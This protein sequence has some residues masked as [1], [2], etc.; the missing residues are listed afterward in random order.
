M[1]PQA[2]GR[3]RAGILLALAADLA[4]RM[5]VSAIAQYVVDVGLDVI[6]ASAGTLCLLETAVDEFVVVAQRGYPE[7]VIEAWRRFPRNSPAPAA[8]AVARREPVY[9]R[10]SAAVKERYPVF[11]KLEHEEGATAILPVIARGRA[12]GAVAFTFDGEREFDDE[13]RTFLE[14]M[15]RHCA[16]ALDRA[17]IHEA[18]LRRETHLALIADASSVLAAQGDDLTEA[19]RSVARLIVPVLSD[20]C[21][22]FLVEGRAHGRLVA[23]AA[24]VPDARTT[25][26]GLGDEYRLDIAKAQR[27]TP[28]IQTSTVV[29]WEEGQSF[30]DHIGAPDSLRR[31]MSELSIGPGALVPLVARGRAV[32]MLALANR[33]GRQPGAD[34][35]ALA[36]TLGQRMAVLIDNARLLAQTTEISRSLQ[37]SLLPPMLPEIEGFEIAAR[38]KAAGEGLDVGGDFYDVIALDPR[39]WL[40]VVGDVAGHGIKAAAVT[41]LLRHTIA[42]A[43]RLGSSLDDTLTHV[44]DVLR[45]R[46]SDSGTFAT[47]ALVE[48]DVSSGAMEVGCAGHPP[49]LLRRVDGTVEELHAHGRLLGFFDDLDAHQVKAELRV[50]DA[51]VAFTDGVTERHDEGKWFGPDEL[52]DLLRSCSGCS[53]E[54]MATRIVD[55][56]VDAFD[57]APTDDIAVVVVR[58][59]A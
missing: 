28:A 34:E 7:E 16:A 15:T 49:P 19:L 11:A 6:G 17:L 56:V 48:L 45:S 14:S 1:T 38:Y 23:W 30:L 5:D 26:T 29:L 46:E 41:G 44:N 8:D 36:Q 47:A 39:R 4:E 50:G 42:G 3:D 59:I 13:E 40:V 9:L 27:L 55:S 20:M 2:M 18:A 33:T 53:A 51:V 10:S 58:R 12:L 57:T 25:A 32:G 43:A 37:A 54:E 35:T 52:R 22:I 31:A 24:S 21:A